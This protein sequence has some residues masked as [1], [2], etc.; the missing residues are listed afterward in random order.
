MK[1]QQ[2][3][4]DTEIVNNNTDGIAV[5]VSAVAEIAA[6]AAHHI[7]SHHSTAAAAAAAAATATATATAATVAAAAINLTQFP[8]AISGRMHAG[9]SSTSGDAL[10][11]FLADDVTA[12]TNHSSITT[13]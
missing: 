6:I 1:I 7:P 2:E 5:A 13:K 12:T 9:Y 8:E 11:P 3:E 10:L 4:D